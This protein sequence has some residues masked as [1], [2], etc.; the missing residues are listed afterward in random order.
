[1]DLYFSLCVR[2]LCLYWLRLWLCNCLMLRVCGLCRIQQLLPSSAP[3]LTRSRTSRFV[4]VDAV[5]VLVIAVDAKSSFFSVPLCDLL[6][7]V[8]LEWKLVQIVLDSPC[9]VLGSFL[10]SSTLAFLSN[11][12]S[13]LDC[14]G[15]HV[16]SSDSHL[17]SAR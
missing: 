5:S 4:L 12:F 8:C 13:I 3:M 15:H 1:M 9:I 17:P 6:I 2:L 11:N 14:H 16:H 7:K 10:F